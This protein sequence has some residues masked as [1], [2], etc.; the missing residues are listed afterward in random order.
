VP[1]SG[2]SSAP[3]ARC[4]R[5]GGR[6]RQVGAREGPVDASGAAVGVDDGRGTRHDGRAAPSFPAWFA[7][8]WGGR[9]GAA[10]VPC[11][12]DDPLRRVAA[13]VRA[14][15]TRYPGPVGELIRRELRAFAEVGHRFDGSGL[16]PRLIDDLLAGEDPPRG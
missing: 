7:Q 3:Q 8:H 11:P 13:A 10:P 5:T 15:G 2:G 1:P 14:A 9:N 12:Y 4:K 6:S 16:V